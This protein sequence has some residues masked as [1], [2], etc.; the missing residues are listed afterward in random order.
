MVPPNGWTSGAQ[1]IV[2]VVNKRENYTTSG[3]HQGPSKSRGFF[4]RNKQLLFIIVLAMDQGNNGAVRGLWPIYP[5]FYLCLPHHEPS[6]VFFLLKMASPVL[7]FLKYPNKAYLL[8]RPCWAANLSRRGEFHSVC[9]EMGCTFLKHIKPGISFNFFHYKIL[10]SID[11]YAWTII[12]ILY[13]YKL[14]FKI[15]WMWIDISG[16]KTVDRTKICKNSYTF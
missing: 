1:A 6:C 4:L 3:W 7:F 13:L 8:Y 15:V 12:W 9:P 10:N 16:L 5:R 2:N 14:F 11:F